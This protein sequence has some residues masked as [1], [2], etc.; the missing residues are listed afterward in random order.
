MS[1]TYRALVIIGAEIKYTD[2]FVPV[3]ESI[4]WEC[5][6]GHRRPANTSGQFCSECGRKYSEGFDSAPTPKFLAYA[7]SLR[8]GTAEVW[9]EWECEFEPG[10][11][12]AYRA[13]EEG[14][15]I[16]GFMISSVSYNSLSDSNTLSKECLEKTWQETEAL[17][18]DIGLESHQ[19]KLHT[20]LYVS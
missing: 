10:E 7:R 14:C 4:K 17:L 16:L 1:T 2:L 15:W 5:S 8:Q 9:D 19:V 3:P 13:G 20:I 18:R 11:I 6:Y 12:C